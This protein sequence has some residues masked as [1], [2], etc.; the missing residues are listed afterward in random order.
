MRAGVG[1]APPAKETRS[2]FGDRGGIHQLSP[3]AFT[4][5]PEASSPARTRAAS[6]SDPGVSLWK[7]IVSA[8]TGTTVPS[9][10]TIDRCGRGRLI[11]GGVR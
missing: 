7:H 1:H 11:A 8:T 3:I 6:T 5:M 2:R 10:A 9:T 4:V